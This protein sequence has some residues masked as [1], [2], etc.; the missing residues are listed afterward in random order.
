ME[1][2]ISQL[3]SPQKHPSKRRLAV[4]ASYDRNHLVNNYVVYYLKELNKVS[5]IIFVADNSLSETEKEKI[6][7]LTINIIAERHG[8]YDF[9][10]YKR[11]YLWAEENDLIGHY[12]QLIYCN[13]SVFGPIHPFGPIFSSMEKKQELDFWGMFMIK[14]EAK[15]EENIRKKDYAHSYFIVFSCKVATSV[16]FNNFMYGITKLQNKDAIIKEYE[17][18]LS[19]ILINKGFRGDGYMSGPYN[20]PH[21]KGALSLIK[22][23]F[24]FLKKSL[25][26]LKYLSV[27]AWCYNLWRY[28]SIIAKSAPNYPIH[29]T[30]EYLHSYVGKKKLQKQLLKLRF[31]IPV[32][33]RFFFYKKVTKSGYLVVKILSIP[34]YRRKQ[35]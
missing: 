10:S 4:F 24:P 19:Q 33:S 27:K 14:A 34:V 18:G 17:V 13:D 28:K 23:G 9:G 21:R 15:T 3:T 1:K 5:D 22:N 29:F 30:E 35:S 8:E 26:D 11:G 2:Q 12:E 31:R 6:R 25:F 32:I 7:P 20:T 16:A